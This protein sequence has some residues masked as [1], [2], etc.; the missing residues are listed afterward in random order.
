[1]FSHFLSVHPT[2]LAIP[3]PG[4]PILI[5]L[6]RLDFAKRVDTLVLQGENL[7]RVDKSKHCQFIGNPITKYILKALNVFKE[8]VVQYRLQKHILHLPPI[9]QYAYNCLFP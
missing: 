6:N 7:L 2:V 8:Q 5:S 4:L 9:W 3:L 1:M